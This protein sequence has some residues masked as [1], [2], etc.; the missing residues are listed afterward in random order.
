M[1]MSQRR[2]LFVGNPGAA[3]VSQWAAVRAMAVQQGW[4][5]TRR[6]TRGLVSCA[7]VSDRVRDGFRSPTES[8]MI[9]TLE[10]DAVP[11]SV[12]AEAGPL[13]LDPQ[14]SGRQR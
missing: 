6:Y 3:E 13:L 12:A 14:S 10:G 9:E 4:Q 11:Y 5:T 2:V 1:E 7:V 8:M